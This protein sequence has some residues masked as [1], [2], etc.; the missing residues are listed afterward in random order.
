MD[1]VLCVVDAPDCSRA[2]AGGGPLRGH[3]A[4]VLR[5]L[6]VDRLVHGQPQLYGGQTLGPG[7]RYLLRCAAFSRRERRPA[8]G[9]FPG[10][11]AAAGGD[12]GATGRPAGTFAA[13][14][15]AGAVV[16]GTAP[17]YGGD[18][19]GSTGGG[20]WRQPDPFPGQPGQAPPDTRLHA[21]RERILEPIWDSLAFALSRRAPV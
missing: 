3:G 15:R 12:R 2:R 5:A 21:Q 11:T 10:W 1:G 18:S 6:H 9:P 13:L 4:E 19:H 17:V 7:R 8:Q 14:L 16:S 20:S